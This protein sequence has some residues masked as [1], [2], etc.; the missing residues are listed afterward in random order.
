VGTNLPPPTVLNVRLF[1]VKSGNNIVLSWPASTAP[2]QLYA[3]PS[4]QPGAWSP[5]T[6]QP[7]IINDNVVVTVPL[8]GS[9][10]YFRL[11]A[12]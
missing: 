2:C 7:L 6:T 8:S 3:M 9:S 12:Q 4:V 11:Q 1:A 5:V 10:C